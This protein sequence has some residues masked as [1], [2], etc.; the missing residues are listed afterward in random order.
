MFVNSP[1]FGWAP[2]FGGFPA[3]GARPG[4][5]FSPFMGNLFGHSMMGQSSHWMGGGW[6]R[7]NHHHHHHHAGGCGGGHR[8]HWSQVPREGHWDSSKGGFVVGASGQ[9]EASIRQPDADF[10]NKIQYRTARGDWQDLGWS[11]DTG[12]TETIHARPGSTVEFR[13]QT[14]QGNN[15]QAGTTNNVDGRDHGQVTSTGNGVRIGFEDLRDN[16]SFDDAILDIRH[17]PRW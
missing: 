4:F 7:P 2:S 1:Q 5:G 8:P 17:K 9:L 15:F 13:I 14:P 10:N 3:M 12:K 16:S 11:K 6:W